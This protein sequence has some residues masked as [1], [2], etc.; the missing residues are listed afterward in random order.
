MYNFK[1][2]SLVDF[3]SGIQLVL[4]NLSDR[5]DQV[6]LD[7]NNIDVL[8]VSETWFDMDNLSINPIPTK[9]H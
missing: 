5:S 7:P 4:I 9:T 6:D 8:S 1:R 2:A 3:L